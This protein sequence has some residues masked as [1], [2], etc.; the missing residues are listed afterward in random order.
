MRAGLTRRMAIA[1]ALLALLTSAV[2]L[3]LLLAVD[4]QRDSARRSQHAQEVL[5]TTSHLERLLVD[6]ETGTR[7]YL[8]TGDERFLEPLNAAQAEF[9]EVGDRLVALIVDPGQDTRARKITERGES[10]IQDYSLPLVEAARRNDPA[11]R[12]AEKAEEGRVLSDQL[13]RQFAVL[14]SAE[15]RIA[16]ESNAR[17]RENAARATLAAVVGLAG[18]ILLIA[19]LATYLTRAIVQPVRQAA[20][21][22]ERL[23]GGD[24]TIRM[25]EAGVAE[26]G[27]LERAFNTMCVSLERQRDQLAH[28]AKEQAA[29]RR[30]ATLVARGTSPD[31]VFPAVTREVAQV[32]DVDGARMVRYDADGGATVIANWGAPEPFPV[33]TR[34]SLEGRSVTALVR[35]T[36]QPARIEGY[37]EAPG[38]I[39]AT[40][41]EYGLRSG[42]GAPIVVE[43]QVWGTMIVF[44][45]GD[46]PLPPDAE[47][48]LADFTDLIGT[49]I[50]NTQA[51]AELNASR[52]RV[53]ATTDEIRRRIERDLH[54]GTQQRLVSLTLNLRNAQAGVPATQPE[55]RTRLSRIADGLVAAVD[56]LQEISRG[57]HPAVL[58]SGGL[59]PA[60]KALARRS[61]IVVELDLRLDDRLPEQIEVAAY[62]VV[63]EALANAAKHAQATT[64]RVEAA[65]RDGRLQLAV[66]DD[67]IG[68]ADPARGSGLIGLTDRVEALGGTITL[69]SPPGQ[70][71]T[72]R[73]LLPA[74]GP[75]GTI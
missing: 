19:F 23:A 28:M 57:I 21:M 62:Y 64:V 37:E 48:R 35:Q 70:G 27:V 46:D 18:S 32:L 9:P 26:I 24:L 45:A 4:D 14:E 17:T 47:S 20:A 41:R 36:G 52:A 75:T 44:P 25:P 2:F 51:R 60:L 1:S 50:A 6:A 31:E 40:V 29:L 63:A 39:A 34:L 16:A 30:V 7:G 38:P 8:L 3:A 54:D 22:A 72:L 10:F 5:V 61:P 12:S 56:D 65:V 68:G 49:A 15:R 69:T 67:G 73:V 59:R 43:G 13:R 53:V 71:T 55:L 66:R 11:A 42:V 58:S 74:A 33:G